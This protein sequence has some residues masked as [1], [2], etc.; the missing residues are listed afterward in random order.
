ML[1]APPSLHI[2]F[3]LGLPDVDGV[4]AWWHLRSKGGVSAVPCTGGLAD[5]G[6]SAC[7]A[8]ALVQVSLRLSAVALWLGHHSWQCDVVDGCVVCAVWRSLEAIR[9]RPPAVT[10]LFAGLAGLPGLNGFADG[11]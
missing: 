10:S 7:F 3:L 9:K 8:N 6:E 4:R 1:L 2:A 11:A 5:S